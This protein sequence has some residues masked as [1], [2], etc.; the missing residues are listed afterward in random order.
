MAR[1]LESYRGWRRNN[2]KRFGLLWHKVQAGAIHNREEHVGPRLPFAR[3]LALYERP[4][5]RA[6][7]RVDK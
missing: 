1:A 7:R 5:T 2:A 6:R 3:A 4:D